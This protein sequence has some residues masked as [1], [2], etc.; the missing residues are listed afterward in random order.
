[1]QQ[2]KT[3]EEMERAYYG[4]INYDTVL[5]AKD[6]LLSSDTAV[7]HKILGAKVWSYLNYEPNVL[8][9]L[10][11]EPMNSTSWRAETAAGDSFPS[12]GL[13]E[14]AA[15][16]F[17]DIADTTHP[18]LA[19]MTATPK[20]TDHG[21]GLTWLAYLLEGKDDTISIAYL[22]E[23]KGLAH[24][25]ALNAAL[26]QDVDTPASN[27]VES[28]DRAASSSAE[29]GHCSAA[30]DPDIYGKDRDGST[31]YDAK[32][33]SSGSSAATLRELTVSLIDGVYNSVSEAGGRT[34]VIFTRAN[35]VKVWSSL[36]E[37]ALRYAPLGEAKFVPRFN[38]A[39]GVGP[40]FE[41]GF[42]VATYNGIP[43][44]PTPDYNSSRA[45]ARTGEVG[46]IMFADT[47][48]LRFAVLRPTSYYES[49]WPEDSIPLNGH[50]MEGHYITVGEL[51]CYNF[52]AQGKVTD[53]K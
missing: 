18:T 8:T 49:R 5:K 4:D 48:F 2:F 38:G 42:N 35:T 53:I 37:G 34:D 44:I 28:I 33:A 50:G 12:G 40:G 1:M 43:I 29:A 25:R 31:A 13:A 52:A 22:R 19:S 14:G 36:L 39:V 20:L 3:I 17:T 6:A 23:Q 21:F 11:K 30:T 24:A 16:N 47:R 26:C 9:G 15:S 27:S 7:W 32:V 41:V 46:P 51:K 10:P 45:T